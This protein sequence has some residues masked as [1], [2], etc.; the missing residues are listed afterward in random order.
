MAV[1]TACFTY[2]T[3]DNWA[4]AFGKEIEEFILAQMNKIP[5]DVS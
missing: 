1:F 3:Q 2:N 5:A 4:Y